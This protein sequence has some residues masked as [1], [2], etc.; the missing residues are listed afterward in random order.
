MMRFKYVALAVALAFGSLSA[1]AALVV[2]KDLSNPVVIPGLTGF[3]SDG[4]DMAGMSVTVRFS[5]V[6][7][8]GPITETSFWQATGA[9]SGHAVSKLGGWS[10]SAAGD[11][12]NA[13]WEFRIDGTAGLGQ[14]E[15]FTLDGTGGLTVFDTTDPA[16]GTEGSANGRSFTLLSGCS[17]PSCD[18]TIVYSSPVAIAP[19]VAVGD[20]F[21][22]MTVSFTGL[23]GPSS[24]FTFQQDTDSDSRLTNPVPEPGTL[25]LAGLALAGL[26]AVRRRAAR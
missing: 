15:S 14:L 23:T 22:V 20:I 10:L 1:Q 12:F 7:D 3:A 4:A 9:T 19:N 2:S 25:A 26:G 18:G 11:T 21:H 24:T 16:P 6:N 17:N 5:G 13:A 8:G